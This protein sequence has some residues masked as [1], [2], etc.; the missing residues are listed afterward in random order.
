MMVYS[1]RIKIRKLW[2]K[3]IGDDARMETCKEM[4]KIEMKS[5]FIPTDHKEL[6]KLQRTNITAKEHETT[7]MAYLNKNKQIVP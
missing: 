3:V 1:E 5:P 7:M 2:R 4:R 6:E